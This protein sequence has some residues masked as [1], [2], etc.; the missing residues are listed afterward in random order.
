MFGKITIHWIICFSIQRIINQKKQKYNNNNNTNLDL[1]DD[2]KI[3]ILNQR[4]YLLNEIK[5]CYDIIKE[6]EKLDWLEKKIKNN[7]K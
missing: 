2:K 5:I 7:G 4:L 1:E 6:R 3:S